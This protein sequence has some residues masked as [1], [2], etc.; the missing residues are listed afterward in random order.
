MF[1]AQKYSPNVSLRGLLGPADSG[2][3]IR[4]NTE[5]CL[6]NYRAEY[7][8]RLEY[9]PFVSITESSL[10]MTF[11]LRITKKYYKCFVF[12]LKCHLNINY[13]HSRIMTL[14]SVLRQVHSLFQSEF[15]TECDLVV[16]VSISS[17]LF[18]LKVIQ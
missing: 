14:L 3:T 16:P 18:F 10:R 8:R 2:T 1:I 5:K 15:L 6:P 9:S 11:K 12:I 13:H 4:R 17:I 7:F